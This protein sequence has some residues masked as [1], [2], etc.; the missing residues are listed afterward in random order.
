[1]LREWMAAE[2]W[3]KCTNG[4][5]SWFIEIR[6]DE[7]D[8]SRGVP[9]SGAGRRPTSGLGR[10]TDDEWTAALN[11]VPA[12]ELTPERLR[13]ASLVPAA[14]GEEP[15]G[16]RCAA[17]I[18]HKNAAV[19]QSDAVLKI[20]RRRRTAVPE[21]VHPMHRGRPDNAFVKSTHWL[22]KKQNKLPIRPTK[23]LHATLGL[24]LVF[25]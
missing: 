24:S 18:R 4:A 25:R 6:L 16:T 3:V 14:V 15:H 13:R 20:Q 23:E 19:R 11:M 5:E 10:T 21:D 22:R 7:V 9:Q 1:M 12:P 2:A 8:F 17:E